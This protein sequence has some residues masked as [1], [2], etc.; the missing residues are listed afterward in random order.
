MVSF[1]YSGLVYVYLLTKTCVSSQIDVT[2]LKE[3]KVNLFKIN[4]C[5]LLIQTFLYLGCELCGLVS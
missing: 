4:I 3:Q 5:L 2:V 1:L